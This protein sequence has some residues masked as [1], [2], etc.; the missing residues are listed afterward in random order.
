MRQLTCS[1]LVQNVSHIR[2]VLQHTSRTVAANL[3]LDRISDSV[4]F[5]RTRRHQYDMARFHD[6]ADAH[7]DGSAG[8]VFSLVEEPGVVVDSLVVEFGHMGAAIE[9]RAG[10]VEADMAIGPNSKNLKVNAS[11]SFDLL[12]VLLTVFCDIRGDP[13]GHKRV[14]EVYVVEKLLFHEVVVSL[15]MILIKSNVFV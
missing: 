4:G 15:W 5:F 3:T 7:S 13:F 6:R 8:N 1:V 10:F 12:I 11:S 14:L 2:M 9:S